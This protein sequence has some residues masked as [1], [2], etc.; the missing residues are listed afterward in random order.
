MTKHV[1]L[2]LTEIGVRW[3]IWIHDTTGGTVSRPDTISGWQ[4][5][6]REEITTVIGNIILE[7][8]P[9]SVDYLDYLDVTKVDAE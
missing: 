1:L 6:N 8:R 2:T 5:C 9:T 7:H 4:P 3:N